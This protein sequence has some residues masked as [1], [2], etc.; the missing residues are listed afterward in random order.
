[1]SNKNNTKPAKQQLKNG[2]EKKK[3]DATRIFL[4][5]FA[6]VALVGIL[7]SVIV[8]IALNANKNKSIDYMKTNLSKYVTISAD[9][10]SSYD[11]KIEVPEVTEKDLNNAIIKVLCKNKIVPDDKP[12]NRPNVTL[13]VGDVANIYYRGYTL[14]EDGEKEY[15]DGGCNFTDSTYYSLEIGSGS[16]ISGF[17]YNLIGKNQK[18]YATFTKLTSGNTASGDIIK[19]TYSSY[20][21]D[22]TARMAQTAI[23][24]LSDPEAVDEE[25]G[26]GFAE[27]FNK[28]AGKPI[29]VKFGTDADSEN[30]LRVEST[31]ESDDVNPTDVY[32]DMTISEAYRISE[33]ERLVVETYFPY[34]YNEESLRNKTAYFEVYIKTAQDYETPE[35]DDKFITETLKLKAEDLASFEG[36][37]LVEKYK[38]SLMADLK[39]E[40]DAK[41]RSAVELALWDHVIANANYKKLPESEVEEQYNSEIAEINSLYASGY[42]SYYSS[43]DYF[44]LAYLGLESGSDWKKAVRDNAETAIKQKLAFYYIIREENLIPEG[45]EYDAIYEEIFDEHLQTYLDYYKI[46]EDSEDYETKLEDAKNTVKGQFD[47]DYWFELVVYDYA[48]EKLIANA[49]KI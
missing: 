31:R 16:F 45:E 38:S 42:S 20:H 4:I 11:V 22:G 6:S 2:E 10:Y 14:G 12:I 26:K 32:F 25:W 30:K 33:G 9:V 8:A 19:L 47:D 41:V 29:G 49:N 21:A 24:D 46:T 28:H 43:V 3:L 48:I 35:L 13:S 37:T 18:D 23:I 17:E 36:E 39:E 7:A 40:Y 44:A 34:D 1:M 15:F 5:V 27:Y